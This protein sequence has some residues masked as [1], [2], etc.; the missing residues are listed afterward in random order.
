MKQFL[1]GTFFGSSLTR[2]NVFQDSEGFKNW[3]SE[4]CKPDEFKVEV[5]ALSKLDK[6]K[7]IGNG[8]RI[9]HESGRFFQI[10]GIHV[11]TNFGD[12]WAWDQPIINQPEIGFLGFI[13][14]VFDGV[15]YFL[16][17]AK[18]EPGNINTLQISPSLQATKSNF[19]QVHKGKRPR[20]LEYFNGEKKVKILVDQLQ[21]EQ[22]GRF[23]K[24][25]NR[26]IIVEVDDEVEISEDFKWLTLGELKALLRE[27][28]ILNMDTRSVLSTVPLIEDQVISS[29]T[30]YD[31]LELSSYMSEIGKRLIKSF[32]ST[33][34]VNTINDVL[35]WYTEQMTSWEMYVTHKPLS[36]LKNWSLG[37]MSLENSNRY[38]SVIGVNVK[39]GTR[40]VTSWMQP[41]LEDNHIGLLAFVCQ[42]INGVIHFLVQAKVE[43][44]NIDIV[45]LS[46]TVSCSN[47]E[48]VAQSTNRHFMFDEL[49]SSE[50]TVIFDS[51][52]SEEGGRFYKIQNRNMIV[53]LPNWKRIDLPKNFIW[54]S[55]GQM[56]EFMR[57]GMFNI[58]ARSIISAISFID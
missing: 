30:P 23:F 24:K 15:R 26:N 19:T 33:S 10:D 25:R 35:S 9:E 32:I 37:E 13:T 50:S 1:D 5:V 28:N 11:E 53:E 51:L 57:Y 54:M 14:K 39:A 46:P 52:Q 31:L 38:F 34:T 7:I 4:R 44:G 43:P 55:L 3:F 21:S 41:L 47:Y 2:K 12:V 22:G 29:L 17:Q 49:F 56:K 8:E 16:V 6:W 45:E 18:M 27:D 40:E 20:Y 42:E 36:Q 58:E 48:Y